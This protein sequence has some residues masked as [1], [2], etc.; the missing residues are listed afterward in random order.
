MPGGHRSSGCDTLPWQESQNNKPCTV[1]RAG[2]RVHVQQYGR[3]AGGLGANEQP[4]QPRQIVGTCVRAE[5]PHGLVRRRRR[6]RRVLDVLRSWCGGGVEAAVKAAR[7]WEREQV[8]KS[9]WHAQ[10]SVARR[11]K[12]GQQRSV[13]VAVDVCEVASSRRLA[14]RRLHD[15]GPVAVPRRRARH[16]R[17]EGRRKA[18]LRY[19]DGPKVN[20]EAASPAAWHGGQ[21]RRW[22]VLHAKRLDD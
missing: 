6:R 4:L 20:A 14:A 8:P 21:R 2:R 5:T 22:R 11:R 9:E 1:R 7:P 19:K 3:E 12:L 18:G 16:L 10:Q 17:K 13:D 15:R